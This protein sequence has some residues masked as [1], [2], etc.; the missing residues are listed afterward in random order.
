[1]A[2]RHDKSR[3]EAIT[4]MDE[5]AKTAY[6]DPS[7]GEGS[8]SSSSSRGGSSKPREAVEL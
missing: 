7:D 4:L 1:M 8:S 3:K 2:R 5:R 6:E